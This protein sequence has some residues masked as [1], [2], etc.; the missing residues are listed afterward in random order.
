MQKPN[1]ALLSCII[2]LAVCLASSVAELREA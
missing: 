1:Y 2:L